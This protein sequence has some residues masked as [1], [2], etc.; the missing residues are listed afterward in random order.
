M[1]T[2]S[3]A[4]RSA[5]AAAWCPTPGLAAVGAAGESLG[6]LALF[7]VLLALILVLGAIFGVA[8]LLKR[9][10]PASQAG[11]LMRVL[12]SVSIGPRERL[13]LVEIDQTWFV[14][15]VAT[16]SVSTV[17]TMPRQVAL[18]GAPREQVSGWLRTLSGKRVP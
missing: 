11:G 17:H 6:L 2:V 1:A 14:L 5:I 15:A 9:L 7:K 10:A 8:W 4:R 12:G 18:L 13:V 16:G 3:A